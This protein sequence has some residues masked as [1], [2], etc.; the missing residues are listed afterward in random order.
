LNKNKYII[1]YCGISKNVV[2]KN[3]QK[4]FDMTTTNPQDFLLST[5]EH[6]NL[7]YSKFY[8][9]DSLNKLGWLASEILL[10]DES[11]IKDV[12]PQDI[13]I[14]LSNANSSLNTDIKYL[15]SVQDFA[16]P[17]LFVYTLP[18]IVIGEVC[19]R[20]DFKGENAFFIFEDFNAVFIERYVSHLLDNNILQLCICG[21]VEFLKDSYKV[22]LYLVGKTAGENGKLFTKETMDD[23]FN[24]QAS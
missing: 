20:N 12:Q 21:W 11:I 24:N 15:Q 7:N 19:I 23:I 13:G 5:Y 22:V 6:F 9:M 10:A 18:N 17:A 3:G 14:V 16:S 1:S 4:I 8:K 2:Y